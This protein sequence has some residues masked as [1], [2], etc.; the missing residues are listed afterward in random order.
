MSSVGRYQEAS[1][2]LQSVRQEFSSHVTERLEGNN[3]RYEE[4]V[5]ENG[6]CNTG[7]L[8]ESGDIG[9]YREPT[10]AR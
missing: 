4:A 7:V 5:G 9:R 6:E 1:P 2:P 8:K 10:V 3:A